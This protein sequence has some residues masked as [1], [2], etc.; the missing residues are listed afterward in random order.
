MRGSTPT[1]DA[2]LAYAEHGTVDEGEHVVV[3]LPQ[4]GGCQATVQII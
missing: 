2:L 4:K 1:Q 3:R